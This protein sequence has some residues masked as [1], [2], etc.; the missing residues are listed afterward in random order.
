MIDLEKIFR[1]T[2]KEMTD[3]LLSKKK[4][5]SQELQLASLYAHTQFATMLLANYHVALSQELSRQGIQLETKNHIFSK[6]PPPD[7]H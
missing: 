2:F 3:E 5:T 1:E 7:E 6:A 4:K